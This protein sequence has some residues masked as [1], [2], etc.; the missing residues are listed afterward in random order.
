MKQ[1]TIKRSLE[2]SPLGMFPTD[3]NDITRHFLC[4]FKNLKTEALI[5]F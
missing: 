3:S 4:C 1:R 5:S 2:K